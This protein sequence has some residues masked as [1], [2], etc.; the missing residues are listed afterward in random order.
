MHKEEL[1]RV[2]R[3][4]EQRPISTDE[5][6]RRVE[7]VRQQFLSEGDNQKYLELVDTILKKLRQKR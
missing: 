7:D 2:L 1:E 6:I 3:E 4:I 5:K